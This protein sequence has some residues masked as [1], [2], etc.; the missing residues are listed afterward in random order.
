ML[1]ARQRE[2]GLRV[3]RAQHD[4]ASGLEQVDGERHVGRVVFDDE[5]A[6]PCQTTFRRPDIARRTSAMNRVRSN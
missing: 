2:P 4:V 3:P 6:S 1:R 5:N